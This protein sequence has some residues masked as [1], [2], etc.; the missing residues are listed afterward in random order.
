MGCQ[1]LGSRVIT[2]LDPEQV[3]DW[4]DSIEAPI[5]AL[6]AFQLLR[7][8]ARL[9]M[10][11]PS[12]SGWPRGFAN[13]F[14]GVTTQKAKPR[15][16]RL[17]GKDLATFGKAAMQH[18]DPAVRAFLLALHV[19]GARLNELRMA[20]VQQFDA[21]R[22]CIDWTDSKNG[23]ERVLTLGPITGRM[24]REVIDKRTHGLIWPGACADGGFDFRKER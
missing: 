15:K 4:H 23:D 21:R 20:T 10:K 24:L 3:Q 8:A 7:A 16:R 13:P 11:H 5:A 6:H 2:D 1:P 17:E 18:P 22:H 12:K 19:S 14:H 9:C